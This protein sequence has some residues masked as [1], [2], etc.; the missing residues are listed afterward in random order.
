M[1][2]KIEIDTK[3]LIRFWLVI[4]GF[5][6]LA[7]AIWIAKDVL[8]M[9]IIA[10]FLALALNSPVAKIAK[11]LPGSSK[12]R[13]GATAVAYLII[14]L[15][16]G[17]LFSVLTPII[18]DQVKHFSKD[19]PQIVQNYTGEQSGIRR[20]IT[21]NHL[22]GMISQAVDS[23]TRS[24]NSSVSK[25]GDVFFGSIASIVGWIISLFMVL[26]MAFLMLVEGPDL[27]DK[28]FKVFYTDKILEKN[29]RRILSRMYG[30][31]SGYVSSIVTICSISATCGS[32]AT[33][34]LAL[35]F[36]FPI[37]LIAPIAVLLFIFG[38]IPMVGTTIAGM[39]SALIIGLNS[40]TAGLI[41][42]AYFLIYQQ[43][44]NNVISPMVQA[45]NNQLSALIIFIA[46]TVG[47]YAFGL[48]GALLAIPLA[49]CAK[50]LVQEQ[51]K[52]RKRRSREENSERLVELLKKIS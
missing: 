36:G 16:F 25:I 10:A 29:H 28:I 27:I 41:F 4:F 35:I 11:I 38:M 2:V 20:F 19:L 42:L 31:V 22:E 7:G 14:V 26:A 5:I 48:L 34:I 15:I 13:V 17:A 3:T 8:I 43:I 44:E 12:N 30:T 39:L 52:S 32:L 51:L 21:E 1:K 6:I 49:A 24:I 46:L 18:T 33:A 23:V 47:V 45:R 50:I 37:S 40:P 9:I